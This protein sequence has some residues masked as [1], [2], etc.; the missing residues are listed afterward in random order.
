MKYCFR[1]SFYMWT[2]CTYSTTI[3]KGSTDNLLCTFYS[4]SVRWERSKMFPESL[5]IRKQEKCGRPLSWM[6]HLIVNVLSVIIRRDAA[7]IWLLL[8]TSLMLSHL[9]W[10][11]S[12]RRPLHKDKDTV[13]WEASTKP[14]LISSVCSI[15]IMKIKL[16]VLLIK[17]KNSFKKF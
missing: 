10:S 12:I 1:E 14:L 5:I 13:K 17:K 11:T 7:F 3:L 9:K 2:L 8:T 4:I 16:W 15:R 6:V